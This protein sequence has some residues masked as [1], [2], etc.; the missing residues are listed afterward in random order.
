MNCDI[1][2]MVGQAIKKI[3]YRESGNWWFHF[4]NG[5]VVHPESAWRLVVG[6]HIARS[7]VDHGQWFGLPAPVDAEVELRSLLFGCKV[8]AA[9]IRDDTR[10]IILLFES[11]ERLEIVPLTSGYESWDIKAPNGDWTYAQGGG[12]LSVHNY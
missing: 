8:Q 12:N 11:G 9:E 4:A 6:G 10:D 5:G 7:N 2:W 1:S 3:V